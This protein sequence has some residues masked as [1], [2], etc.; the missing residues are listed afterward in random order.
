[1]VFENQFSKIQL[2]TACKKSHVISRKERTE[3]ACV[4]VLPIK[5]AEQQQIYSQKRTPACSVQSFFGSVKLYH[6]NNATKININISGVFDIAPVALVRLM[7]PGAS[8]IFVKV[9]LVLRIL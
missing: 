4:L 9:R 7:K 3:A 6:Y 1:M 2:V 5:S 8:K